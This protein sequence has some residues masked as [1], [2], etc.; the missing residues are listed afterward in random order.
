MV[1]NECLMADC[2]QKKRWSLIH[3]K[4]LVKIVRYWPGKVK[5]EGEMLSITTMLKKNLISQYLC[6]WNFFTFT[7]KC[8]PEGYLKPYCQGKMPPSLIFQKLCSLRFCVANKL[9]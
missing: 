4:E 9:T 5:I 3:K 8:Y 2:M 1:K 7:I 6:C